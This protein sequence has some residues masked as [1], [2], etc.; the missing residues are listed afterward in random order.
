MKTMNKNIE[1]NSSNRFLFLS[2]MFGIIETIYIYIYI[3]MY[4][5]VSVTIKVIFFK[6]RYS[7]FKN[8]GLNV[9]IIAKS[10]K[11][12]DPLILETSGRI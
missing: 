3:Y 12:P 1:N 6:D 11:S 5:Y 10:A 2:Q 9:K 8:M 4:I 7:I